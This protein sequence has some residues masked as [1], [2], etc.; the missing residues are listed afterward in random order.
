MATAVAE[1]DGHRVADPPVLIRAALDALDRGQLRADR[2]ASR[3]SIRAGGRG[4]AGQAHRLVQR[5]VK[6]FRPQRRN[7]QAEVGGGFDAV[8]QLQLQVAELV[9]DPFQL[10][11]V[12]GVPPDAS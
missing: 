4:L 12:S 3:C 1:P 9:G 10:P 11:T 6:A 8:G 5:I 2:G 7:E